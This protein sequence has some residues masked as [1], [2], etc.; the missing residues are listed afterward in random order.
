[1]L[2]PQDSP[3]RERKCL[4]GLWRFR[5]D[6]EGTGRDVGWWCRGL[7]EPRDMAVPA[8]FN[9]IAADAA[10][11]DYVGDVWYQT[12]GPGAPRL[13]R[14]AHRR[15]T[16]SPRPTGPRCGSTT[17]RWSR[18]EG[19][20]T[21][22]EADITDHVAPGERG[23]DHRR[24][25]QHADLPDHPAR[26]HRGHPGRRAAALLPRLLQLRRAST[27]SVWLYS[28]AARPRR[29]RHRRHRP[30]RRRPAPSTTPIGAAGADGLAVRVVLRDADGSEVADRRA[31]PAAR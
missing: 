24:R 20:Y 18:H 17:P 14:P 27:A 25:Q 19:G 15:C 11:R 16:S 26:R 31:A 21:P 10:V 29:R 6:P 22:F 13:G 23:P 4:D 1:M 9:D 12:H 28:H 3:T 5:L 2:R 30:G 7:P 8:S